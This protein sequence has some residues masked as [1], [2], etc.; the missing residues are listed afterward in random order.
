MSQATLRHVSS[1]EFSSMY[2]AI[3]EEYVKRG[4][5]IFSICTS[6]SQLSYSRIISFLYFFKAM[7]FTFRV[8]LIV[9]S[10][11]KAKVVLFGLTISL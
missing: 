5:S 8:G 6:N 7:P 11:S 10:L 9:G 3:P 4:K 2:T 1:E